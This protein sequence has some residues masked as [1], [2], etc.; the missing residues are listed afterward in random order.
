MSISHEI[1]KKYWGFDHFRDKQEE[2]INSILKGR[3]TL[4]LLPTGGGKSICFQVPALIKEGICIVVSPLIALMKDQVQNLKSRGI[5]ATAIT[6]GMRYQ[7]I[8]V[9]LENCVNGHYKFLYCSPERLETEVFIARVKRMNVS[10]VVVDEAHCISEWGYDFRPSYLKIAA[11]REYLPQAAILALTATATPKVVTDLQEKLEFKDGQVVTKSFQRENLTYVV[12]EEENK[13]KRLLKIITRLKGSGIVYCSTRRQVRD[14]SYFLLQNKVSS[15]HYHAGLT[16]DER[17]KIQFDW[18]QGKTQVICAT[19]AFGMGIDKPDV[20]FVVHLNLP[21]SIEAYFQEAGRGGRDG[22][23]AY[24]VILF[25]KHDLHQLNEQLESSY[26]SLEE[27]K[28]VY[29][30]LGNYYQIAVG[31]AKGESFSFDLK[32]FAKRYNM[33]SLMIYNALKFLEKDHYISLTE[34][35][36]LPSRIHF[37]V[38]HREL[39]SFKVKSPTLSPLIDLILRSY[40]RYFDEFIVIN[41][42][43]LAKRANT[44]RLKIVKALSHLNQLN[45]LTYHE[46]SDLPQITYT[47]ERLHPNNLTISKETYLF[48]KQA[49]ESRVNSIIQYVTDHSTCRSM[50][51]L[52]YFGEKTDQSCGKCDVCLEKKK[53]AEWTSRIDSISQTILKLVEEDAMEVEAVLDKFKTSEEKEVIKALHHLTEIGQVVMEDNVVYTRA[54][55]S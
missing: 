36:F 21:K 14:T 54:A 52:R 31:S 26:P 42:S 51:L 35:A 18:V 46:Q 53:Q 38:D 33:P 22:K 7:E 32:K 50:Q 34:N 2:V 40:T 5:S 44:S 39:Y 10:F 3:D 19:N 45:I 17:D 1:L 27:I 4:A 12:V 41:E 37:K 49:S 13:L 9:A 20:R 11:L 29:Q 28:R 25:A 23:A 24:A 47:E 16:I 55:D 6:S 8:D 15:A 48:R 43:I 30:A